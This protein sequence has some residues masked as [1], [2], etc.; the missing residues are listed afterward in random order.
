MRAIKIEQGSLEWHKL[1]HGNVTGTT[2]GSAIGTLARQKTLLSK[3]V[4]ERMTEVVIEELKAPAVVRGKEIEPKARQALSQHLNTR[5][6]EVGMLASEDIDGFRLSPDGIV[7]NACGEII[8][9]CEIKCPDSKKHV[10]YL[11]G[12]VI[13]KEYYQ[14]V[15]AP[16]L[17]S[18][19]INFWYFASYDDRNYEQPLFVK[20]MVREDL[21]EIETDR[22]RLRA[23][24]N[25]VDDAHTQLSFG[26][27]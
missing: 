11:L 5:F 2:L 3:I 21:K 7:Y 10:E 1:R 23:F 25:R 24:L 16:F 14:Q 27:A 18:D 4:A 12:N 15:Y 17:L 9:G 13:P 22:E 20:K 6:A 8:G 19:Q 26:A